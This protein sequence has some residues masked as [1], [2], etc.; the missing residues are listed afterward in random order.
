MQRSYDKGER[1]FC[2]E[3]L[4]DGLSP[5]QKLPKPIVTPTSKA[6]V[7]SHDEETTPEDILIKGL[8]TELQWEKI[9]QIALLIFLSLV[10]QFMTN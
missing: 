4:P 6:A 9:S 5:W 1:T 2:G 3:N 10:K 8:C 7:G